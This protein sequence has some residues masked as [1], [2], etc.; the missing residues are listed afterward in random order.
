MTPDEEPEQPEYPEYILP[1]SDF[2]DP[3]C[4]GLFLPRERGNVAEL[5]ECGFVLKTVPL[6]DFRRVQDE[7]QL[8]LEVA[9]KQCPHCGSAILFPGFSSMLAYTCRQCGEPVKV[10][11]K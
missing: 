11:D 4:C 6:A 7:L 8:S 1:H 5:N 9:S 10:S 2:G 3:E